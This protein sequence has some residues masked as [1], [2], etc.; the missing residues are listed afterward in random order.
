METP[1]FAKRHVSEIRP[2]DHGWL[3]YSGFEERD[4]VIGPFV[5]EG[6]ATNEK[7]V[8]VTDAPADRLPGLGAGADAAAFQRSRQL[9]VI[10]RRDACLDRAGGFEP[11]RMLDTLAG[12]VGSAFGQGFRAVRI[13]TDYSWLLNDPGVA[14]LPGVLGCEHRVG[15]A[16]S[17]STMAMAV[18]QIDRCACP[19][20]QLAALRDTHEVLVEVDPEY[21]DNVLR[22]VRTFAP[23]G[24]RVEGELDAARHKAFEDRLARVSVGPDGRR[25]GVRLNLSR[26]RFIDLRGLHLLVRHAVSLDGDDAL[27]L[28]GLQPEVENVIEMVGWHR[29]PGLARGR[30]RV[31]ETEDLA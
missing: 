7:V 6:L 27:I 8:Y 11:A 1:W 19:P 14:D 9:R 30:D 28:D 23:D 18:C 13:T 24:L 16:V 3:A 5:R 12:E 4:R 31:P 17:P 29:L 20:E 15:D 2:G 21:E 25:R 10:S 22:I 26:L